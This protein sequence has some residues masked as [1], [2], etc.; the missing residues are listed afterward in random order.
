MNGYMRV[1][2]ASEALGV[3][4]GTIVTS[5]KYK[6]FYIKAKEGKREAWFDLMGYRKRQEME[7]SLLRTA[8]LFIEYLVHEENITYSYMA[9][10]CNIKVQAL[11][12]HQFSVKRAYRLV[13]WFAVN[14]PYLIKRFDEYYGWDHKMRLNRQ[15]E[16]R[17]C[18]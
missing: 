14:R 4:D 10:K 11:A 8:Q 9:S 15:I 13:R 18:A 6:P 5:A 16:F 2:E 3:T 17:M 7:E 1:K 12:N